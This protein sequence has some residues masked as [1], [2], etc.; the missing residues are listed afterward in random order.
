[1]TRIAGVDCQLEDRKKDLLALGLR[2]STCYE[3]E[4][5]NYSAMEL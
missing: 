1:M 5:M 4:G 2:E 3:A